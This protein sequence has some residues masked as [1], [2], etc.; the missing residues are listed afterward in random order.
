MAAIAATITGKVLIQ[1]EGSE[2]VEVGTIEIPV[3]AGPVE[4]LGREIAQTTVS[5]GRR[6]PKS[7]DL[8]WSED[9]VTGRV[10]IRCAPHGWSFSGTDD[11]A[12]EAI[13]IHRADPV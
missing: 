8:Q 5:I 4:T 13:R 7:C 6:E 10:S 9:Q 3:H 1:I 11:T 12:D 2:P